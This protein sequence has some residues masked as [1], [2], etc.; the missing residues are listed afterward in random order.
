MEIIYCNIDIP[1]A[2]YCH[3]RAGGGISVKIYKIRPKDL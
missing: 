3:Y 2:Q 1:S